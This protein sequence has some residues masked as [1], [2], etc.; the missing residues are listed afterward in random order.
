MNKVAVVILVLALMFGQ[1]ISV[2]AYTDS[3]DI[4]GMNRFIDIYSYLNNHNYHFAIKTNNV[5]VY[6]SRDEAVIV[7]TPKGLN[8][9]LFIDV[10]KPGH[11]TNRGIEVGMTL[12]DIVYAYGSVYPMEELWQK[13]RNEENCGMIYPVKNA[14]YSGYDIVNYEGVVSS[15]LQGESTDGIEFLINRSTKKIVLITFLSTYQYT[16]ASQKTKKNFNVRIML[17]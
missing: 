14:Y 7:T 16:K 11:A 2:E 12:N 4:E 13:H 5:D 9:L 1:K 17:N 10:L 15:L 3:I 6:L 8:S